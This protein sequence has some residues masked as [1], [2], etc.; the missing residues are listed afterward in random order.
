MTGVEIDMVV[1]DSLK[2]L[3]LYEKVFDLQR[4]EVARAVQSFS[5]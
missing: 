1:S 5:Q 3:E 4:V 2:A